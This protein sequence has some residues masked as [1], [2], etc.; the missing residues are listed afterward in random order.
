M[1]GSRGPQGGG[2]GSGS[3]QVPQGQ[4]GCSRSQ[5][6]SLT[7]TGRA[8]EAAN[9]W[10]EKGTTTGIRAGRL[11]DRGWRGPPWPDGSRRCPGPDP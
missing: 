10:D 4:G 11:G 5:V 6:C 7:W 9:G 2:E 1:G 8:S 3:L